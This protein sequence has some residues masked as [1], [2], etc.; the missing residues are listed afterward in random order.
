MH[1]RMMTLIEWTE[2]HRN[3]E[4]AISQPICVTDTEHPMNIHPFT[5]KQ[6]YPKHS[7]ALTSK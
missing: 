2:T 4:K 3:Q 5:R 1:Q 6:K 7:T